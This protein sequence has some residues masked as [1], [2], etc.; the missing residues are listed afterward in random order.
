MSDAKGQGTRKKFFNNI[1]HL[2]PGR[3]CG[4]KSLNESKD[5]KD[6]V[7]RLAGTPYYNYFQ[8]I[9]EPK[10]NEGPEVNEENTIDDC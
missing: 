5:Y 8:R 1:G 10:G 2:Y 6:F 3:T 9:P 7:E 4:D